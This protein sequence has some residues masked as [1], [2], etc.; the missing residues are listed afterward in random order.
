MNKTHINARC[1]LAC[2]CYLNTLPFSLGKEVKNSL[3]LTG[4]AITSLIQGQ[5]PKDWD[6]YIRDKSVL[7][8]LC[9][10]YCKNLKLKIS[11]HD[12]GIKIHVPDEGLKKPLPKNKFTLLGKEIEAVPIDYISANAISL[13]GKFQLVTRFSGDPEEIH[14][15]YDFIHCTG[16]YTYQDG[17]VVNAGTEK[18]IKEKR[19]KY[20]GGLYPICSIIRMKKFMERGYTIHPGDLLKL[21]Y[22]VSKLD[23]DDPEVLR[24]QLIGHYSNYYTKLTS[25]ISLKKPRTKEDIFA[26]I[27]S[28][29]KKD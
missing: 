12:T 22:E 13:P 19:L 16:Y 6:F 18:A 20:A 21:M 28:T 27:D 17:L 23:L 10:Y 9:Q 1:H 14:K 3:I 4:G 7:K 15:N 29:I 26:L 8:K 5:E 2:L 24:D 25:L 11:E